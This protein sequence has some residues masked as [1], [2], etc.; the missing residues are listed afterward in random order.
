MLHARRSLYLCSSDCCCLN[1]GRGRQSSDDGSVMSTPRA[2]TE[3]V[4]VGF[5]EPGVS[6][7]D[8]AAFASFRIQRASS[9]HARR[10]CQC[11]RTCCMRVEALETR[12]WKSRA[13][14]EF[15]TCP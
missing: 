6:V 3:E 7:N 8:K 10:G 15:S 12:C 2:A 5:H 4:E 9:I 11:G 14:N 1:L 13:A